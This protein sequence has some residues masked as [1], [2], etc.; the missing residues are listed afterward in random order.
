MQI[1][2]PV[3]VIIFTIIMIVN[4]NAFAWELS[5]FAGVESLGFLHNPLDSR[6]H[7]H[8]LSG[9]IE[10]ELYH[11]WDDGQQSFAF[12]PFY[13]YSQHD[14]RRT[15]FDIRELTWLKVAESWELRVGFR[16]VFWGVT[17]S[18]HLV[19]IINQTDLVENL[20][21]E[22]K[23]GQPMINLALIDEDW[24]T[25]DLFLL[26]GFRER[27]FPG[28]EGR[29]RTMPYVD[30]GNA[31]FEKHG[32]EKHLSYAVRWSHAIGDWDIGFSHFY[33]TTREPLLIPQ[34]SPAGKL[35]L[36]PRYDMIHQTGLDVQTTKGSW[37]WKLESII[38][39]GQ[40]KTFFAATGGL[41]YTFYDLYTTGLD[42]G[43]VFEYLYDSSGSGGPVIFQDDILAA[44][45]FG[46]NDIQS[47]EILAGVI[48]DRTNNAKFY[49]IEASR[50][51][52]ASWKVELEARFFSGVPK[53]DPFFM[54][55]EDD[56]IRME[57]SY[58]F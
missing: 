1:Y 50:R 52:G 46:F 9:V 56:H 11:E 2:S 45:R 40:G 48:F 8:Y 25:L 42:L 10:T 3:R 35:S 37:L 13:R 7:N 51:L 32:V 6:Q 30:V 58:H 57:L 15:H 39:S 16:K 26:T 28:K 34:V 49:N 55:R 53:S 17:E 14:N 44:M 18:R 36:I 54:I 43:F 31:R 23:L 27:T 20:D 33:G 5:G 24:G 38:R 4:T 19:D 22:D 21:T 29:M 41:E 47:T 12:V